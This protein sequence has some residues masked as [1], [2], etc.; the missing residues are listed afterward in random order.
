MRP[1]SRKQALACEHARTERC[2]C[3]C[4]GQFHGKSH[5]SLRFCEKVTGLD[6]PDASWQLALPYRDEWEES[7]GYLSE[8][9]WGRGDRDADD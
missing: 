6:W 2:R 4:M 7:N 3:R 1:L 9:S 5:D 8:A